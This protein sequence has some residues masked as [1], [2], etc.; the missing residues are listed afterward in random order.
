[1]LHTLDNTFEIENRDGSIQLLGYICTPGYPDCLPEETVGFFGLGASLLSL[2]LVAGIGVSVG[3]YYKLRSSILWNL[4]KNT[5][6]L[7]QEFSSALFQLGNRLGD[8]LPAEI[9]FSKVAANMEG[10]T[11]GDFFPWQNK[12]WYDLVWGL[13]K[14]FW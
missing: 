11:S 10:S 6:K 4:R 5:K 14:H 9:A 3:L 13:N 7:E 12:T 2:L 1:M 8:G